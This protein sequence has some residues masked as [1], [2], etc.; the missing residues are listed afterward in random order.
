[1]YSLSRGYDLICEVPGAKIFSEDAVF[2]PVCGI[3]VSLIW[4]V[5]PLEICRDRAMQRLKKI[6]SP[7]P[8]AP[9]TYSAPLIHDEIEF[10]WEYIWSRESRFHTTRLE[11]SGTDSGDEMYAAVRGICLL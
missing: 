3:P 1:M 9:V 6:P 4:L 11:F 5:L 10:S 7:F 2:V 8:W